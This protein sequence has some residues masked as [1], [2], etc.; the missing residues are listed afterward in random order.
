MPSDIIGVNDQRVW[1]RMMNQVS[2]SRLPVPATTIDSQNP[3]SIRYARIENETNKVTNEH[4][5][6][7]SS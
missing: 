1:D 6:P 4:D 7:W 2:D 3:R 5:T